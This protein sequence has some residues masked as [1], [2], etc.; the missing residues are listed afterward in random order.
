MILGSLQ[1]HASRQRIEGGVSPTIGTTDLSLPKLIELQDCRPDM[2]V[3]TE[4]AGVRPDG[5]C[6]LLVRR[7]P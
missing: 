6:P 7:Q 3:Q 1:Q 5:D 2:E 4:R